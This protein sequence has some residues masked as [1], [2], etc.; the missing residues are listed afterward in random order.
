MSIINYSN[1]PEAIEGRNRY[2]SDPS[3]REYK[4]QKAKERY[5]KKTKANI[6]I[7]ND[8]TYIT[9][10]KFCE[11][12]NI[13][14]HF[15]YDLV[16]DGVVLPHKQIKSD[17]RY[18]FHESDA[19]MYR[20]FLHEF[21]EFPELQNFLRYNKQKLKRFMNENTGKYDYKNRQLLT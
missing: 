11:I 18:L 4:K 17:R 1:K 7:V 3:Y 9:T 21:L 10:K 8:V 6:I 14:R 12:A 15:L 2:R 16:E 19:Y 20:D 13:K 5:V